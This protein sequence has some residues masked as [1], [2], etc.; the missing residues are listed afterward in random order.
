MTALTLRSSCPTM[1]MSTFLHALRKAL[2]LCAVFREPALAHV[3]PRYNLCFPHPQWGRPRRR[4]RRAP[5]RSPHP[6]GGQPHPHAS[7]VGLP[8][9]AAGGAGGL[10]ARRGAGVHQG[11]RGDGAGRQL[12]PGGC[13]CEW[14]STQ[15]VMLCVCACVCA[16]WFGGVC[17]FRGVCVCVRLPTHASLEL[18][19]A[20]QR[21]LAGHTATT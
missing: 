6:P 11:R 7:T 14:I 13:C 12:G 9:D 17:L 21:A 16:C 8:C 18:E 19:P 10:R 20:C 5:R 2:S 15:V 4:G 3:C 1:L